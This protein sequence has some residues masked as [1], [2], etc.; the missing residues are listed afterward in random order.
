MSD[1]RA[2]AHGEVV[3]ALR[4]HPRRRVELVVS[5]VGRAARTAVGMLLRRRFG[6][7]LVLDLDLDP[8][9]HGASVSKPEVLRTPGFF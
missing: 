2:G 6:S 7:V 9:R 8:L 4:A 3:A 5:V 1:P